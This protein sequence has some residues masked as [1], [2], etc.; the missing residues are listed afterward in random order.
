[1][2]F[3]NI[4]K[5]KKSHLHHCLSLS[6]RKKESK[7]NIIFHRKLCGLFGVFILCLGQSFH[8]ENRNPKNLPLSS[9]I[10]FLCLLPLSLFLISS[11]SFHFYRQAFSFF[12]SFT[13]ISLFV[14]Q[15]LFLGSWAVLVLYLCDLIVMMKKKMKGVAASVEIAPAPA[16]SVY[17]D[18]RV[19]L[20]HQ[21][22]KQDYEELLKVLPSCLI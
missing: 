1:M 13:P 7:E 17:D 14:L 6:K 2:P 19:R 9:F 15:F 3:C 22:L 20:R 12:L 16:C 18:P 4:P 21:S 8:R 10:F 11:S 5:K